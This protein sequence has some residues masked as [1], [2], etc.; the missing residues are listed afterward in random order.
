MHNLNALEVLARANRKLELM[1][2]LLISLSSGCGHG[3]ILRQKEFSFANLEDFYNV[4]MTQIAQI[5]AF[6]CEVVLGELG[7]LELLHGVWVTRN[8]YRLVLHDYALLDERLDH[9]L[10]VNL[11]GNQFVQGV[12]IVLPWQQS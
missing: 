8:K 11:D 1:L 4:F 9:R 12:R 3:N 5:L 10:L 7:L 2:D 6:A